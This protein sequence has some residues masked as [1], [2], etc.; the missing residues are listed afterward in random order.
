MKKEKKRNHSRGLLVTNVVYIID[1]WQNRRGGKKLFFL[2][3]VLLKKVEEIIWFWNI[4]HPQ[5]LHKYKN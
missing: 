1:V 3:G 4:L 5:P 2:H